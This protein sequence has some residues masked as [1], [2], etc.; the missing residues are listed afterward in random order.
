MSIPKVGI[1]GFGRIGRMVLKAIM[2]TDMEV[3]AVN[4]KEMNVETMLYL[5]KYDSIHG[6]YPYPV[7]IEGDQL[8][9]EDQ[10][11]T[12]FNAK[13]PESINWESVGTDY[14][15]ETTG[16][17]NKHNEAVK[18][19]TTGVHRVLVAGPSPDIKMLVYGVNHHHFRSDDKIVS[20][21]TDTTNA[22]A[23][24]AKV[25]HEK[26]EIVAGMMSTV[27]A[28]TADQP[29]LDSPAHK[30]ILREGRQALSNII[31]SS[32]GAAK[33]LGKVIPVLKEKILCGAYR[34]PVDCGSLCEMIVQ[35]AKG[36]DIDEV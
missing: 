22:M 13:K 34:V 28:A 1:N 36:V 8:V 26:Y 24:L 23:L 4:D 12:I 33:C 17:Y 29:V 32:T 21:A 5:L 25:I 27:H 20:A 16:L 6:P 19:L 31:P 18:H 2:D 9:V 15:V 7:K 14:V 35:V 11:I 3:V 10:K 30:H